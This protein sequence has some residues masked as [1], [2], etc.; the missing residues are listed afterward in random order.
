MII[1]FSMLIF[2]ASII[3]YFFFYIFFIKNVNNLHNYETVSLIK[4]KEFILFR[5]NLNNFYY[6]TLI[7]L[8]IH[9][10]RNN[11]L[12]YLIEYNFSFI[13]FLSIILFIYS[14]LFSNFFSIKLFKLYL[15]IKYF[16]KLL[17]ETNFTS[18]YISFTSKFSLNNSVFSIKRNFST[19]TNTDLEYN[20]ELEFEIESN[21]IKTSLIKEE[22]IK[23]FIKTY[24][25]GYLGYTHTRN[26]GSVSAL[27][28]S[29]NKYDLD[30]YIENLENKLK[31]YLKEIPENV[32]Y[33]I[34]L[35]L[36]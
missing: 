20:T 17:N 33:S 24:G 14:I 1:I 4:D 3:L 34:L 21:D 22:A 5:N 15:K 36:R 25:G 32:T 2:Y 13:L 7:I 18:P 12:H 9:I 26:L 11:G 31:E 10:F 8:F 23:N 16:I 35:V 27:I 29:E 28:H 30:K 19:S 6:F